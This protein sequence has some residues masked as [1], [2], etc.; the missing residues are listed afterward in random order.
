[1][2][3]DGRRKDRRS[4]HEFEIHKTTPEVLP[5]KLRKKDKT[6]KIEAPCERALFPFRGVPSLSARVGGYS[7]A[8]RR[9]LS[10]IHRAFRLRG[11]RHA[12][13]AD[14]AP[15]GPVPQVTSPHAHFLPGRP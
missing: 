6:D 4:G 9:R 2:A 5:L 11:R 15:R 8:L 10:Q 1:M 7:A 13:F 14:R 3:K 12:T